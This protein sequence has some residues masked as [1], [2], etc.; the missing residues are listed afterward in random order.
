MNKETKTNRCI[1]ALRFILKPW[2]EDAPVALPFG[3][4]EEVNAEQKEQY[5]IRWLLFDTFP[6][7]VSYQ[8]RDLR[9]LGWDFAH[10]F[11]P[12]HQ[13]NIIRTSLKPGYYDPDIRILNATMDLVKEFVEEQGLD[14]VAWNEDENH[15]WAWK[16]LNEIYHWWTVT[17]PS[18]KMPDAPEISH[19]KIFGE[20]QEKFKEDPDVIAWN[21]WC[22][23][24]NHI[25]EQWCEEEEQMLIKV[26]KVR[27]YLWYA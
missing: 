16:E 10:R 18:R 4:W 2:T 19:K 9:N 14:V 17:Y 21:E 11:V 13:Y 24:H 20:D 25:E 23:Q 27:K 3:G 8:Y 5:P 7:W 6:T 15:Q 12:K 26:A 22:N 1:N